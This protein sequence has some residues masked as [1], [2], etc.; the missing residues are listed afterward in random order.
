LRF[1][2]K[3]NKIFWVEHILKRDKETETLLGGGGGGKKKRKFFCHD[4]KKNE[5]N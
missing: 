2:L 3:T 4:L 5:N 1:P